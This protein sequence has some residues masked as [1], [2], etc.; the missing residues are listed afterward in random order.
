MSVVLQTAVVP[1]Y[2]VEGWRLAMS[3]SLMG[4]VAARTC[5]RYLGIYVASRAVMAVDSDM[6]EWS[7]SMEELMACRTWECHL[8]KIGDRTNALVGRVG[9]PRYRSVARNTYM[10]S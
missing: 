7:P 5:W 2:D 8:G 6:E 10:A 1:S 9:S 3:H 4:S